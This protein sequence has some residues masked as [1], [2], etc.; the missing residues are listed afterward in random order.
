MLLTPNRARP[1]W[2][3]LRAALRAERLPALVERPR[4]AAQ[5][6][7]HRPPETAARHDEPD[8]VLDVPTLHVDEIDLQLDDL[9]AR[10]ALEAHVL[11]LLRLDVGVAAELRGVSL[12][13][14][15]VEAQALLKVHLD[16]VTQIVDR[17]MSTVDR[18]P[19]ILDQLTER[20]GATLDNIAQGVG[21][22]VEELG[23]DAHAPDA[24]AS[25]NALPK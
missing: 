19:Q 21:P 10:V 6:L 8:V 18:N 15:G 11:D 13:I 7:R 24:T 9:K 3:R 17:V 2:S 23:T 12:Q 5:R 22:A 20:I 25:H 4:H 14:K 16:N 1:R